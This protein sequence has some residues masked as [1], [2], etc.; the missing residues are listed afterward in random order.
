[1]FSLEEKLPDL[2]RAHPREPLAILPTP[3]EAVLG[4]SEKLWVKRDD[5]MGMPYGGNKARRMEYIL[6]AAKRRGATRFLTLGG[7]ASNQCLATAFYGRRAGI[8]TTALIYPQPVTPRCIAALRA[9][10]GLGTELVAL[11]DVAT[12]VPDWA[13]LRRIPGELARVVAAA[14]RRGDTV[15]VVPPSSP[16]DSLSFVNAALELVGQIDRGECPRPEAVVVPCGSGGTVAGLVV[17]FALAGVDIPVH[18]VRIAP[19]A[20]SNGFTLRAQMAAIQ[21]LLRKAIGHRRVL[22]RPPGSWRIVQ[23]EYGAGYGEPTAAGL[24]A[25]RALAAAGLTL[26]PTY[27]GKAAA[28]AL[29]LVPRVKGPVLLWNTY[30]GLGPVDL[31]ADAPPQAA[32]PP[33]FN[34]LTPTLVAS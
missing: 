16:D 24:V 5:Q 7:Y 32:L 11:P 1:M 15:M 25:I 29:R 17:G 23:D 6:A 26:E 3:V 18:A 4:F 33:P 13:S 12:G 22:V 30:A 19:A 28:Y 27:T 34:T 14:G 10:Q 8:A 31:V 2:H 20:V 21:H 9:L